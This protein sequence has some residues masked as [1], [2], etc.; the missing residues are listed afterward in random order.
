[1]Y[2]YVSFSQKFKTFHWNYSDISI[3]EEKEDSKSFIIDK[4][5]LKDYT[6]LCSLIGKAYV[7]GLNI[8]WDIF[9]KSRNFKRI[10]LPPYTFD[11]LVHLRY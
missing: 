4:N 11:S 8:N 1:M 2:V 5:A 3:L 7:K 9:Y 10:N 6:G